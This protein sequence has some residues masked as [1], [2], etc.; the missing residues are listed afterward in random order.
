[1][2]LKSYNNKLDHE[3]GVPLQDDYFYDEP[4]EIIENKSMPQLESTTCIASECIR[5]R[6]KRVIQG[7]VLIIGAGI[8]GMQAALDI[9]DKGYKAVIIDKTST[10]GG[11]MVIKLSQQTT[12]PFVPLHLRW[13]NCHVI[14]ISSLLP[15]LKLT[16]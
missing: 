4:E 9:A 5:E 2:P 8:S 7:D 10:I 11:A 13:S 14:P 3:I 15:T 6:E 1:M 16:N 12:V